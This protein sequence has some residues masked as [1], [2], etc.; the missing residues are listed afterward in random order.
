MSEFEKPNTSNNWKCPLCDTAEEK[1][2]VLIKIA[3][4]IKDSICEA[5]QIHKHCLLDGL[6][7]Y[8]EKSLI[9]VVAPSS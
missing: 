7:Y 5:E 9:A 1:P 2:V 3:G 6:W 8:K 4:T